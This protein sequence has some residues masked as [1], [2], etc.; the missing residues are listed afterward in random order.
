MAKTPA[1]DGRYGFVGR[2]ERS[3]D[4]S[5][6]QLIRKDRK[7]KGGKEI[8]TRVRD[9]D[10]PVDLYEYLEEGNL[11][12]FNL[13]KDEEAPDP[14][15]HL[16][17]VN[18]SLFRVV[19]KS[20]DAKNGETEKA[21]ESEELW[22][23]EVFGE[24]IGGDVSGE[25]NISIELD[26][27]NYPV[28][29]KM[30]TFRAGKSKFQKATRKDGCLDENITVEENVFG[31]VVLDSSI[32]LSNIPI[33]GPETAEVTKRVYTRRE[34]IENTIFL[35]WTILLF[36]SFVYGVRVGYVSL[37]TPFSDLKAVSSP[38]SSSDT[39]EKRPKYSWEKSEGNSKSKDVVEIQNSSSISV[40]WILVWLLGWV[41]WLVMIPFF[42]SN[43]IWE[44]ITR[45]AGKSLGLVS[46]WVHERKPFHY[47]VEVTRNKGKLVGQPVYMR[48]G[49]IINAPEDKEGLKTKL[50]DM[51]L[52]EIFN[53]FKLFD[54]ASNIGVT[55]LDRF[56]LGRI[57][58]GK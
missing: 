49:K 46:G 12:E 31:R 14:D 26:K 56:V 15:V 51:D 52:K 35:V 6:W 22:R 16:K 19:S 40:G 11:F 47:T 50:K 3:A 53:S 38:Q 8:P 37:T 23:L 36:V 17:A 4:G 39:S 29:D 21:K 32:S 13:D 44:G 24:P 28:P 45:A 55:L 20:G 30:I 48:S 42:F 1:G 54:V 41:I 2:L 7:D 5:Y 18:I 27:N 9:A 10:I 58:G 43:D 33:A 57:F 34:K 25:W